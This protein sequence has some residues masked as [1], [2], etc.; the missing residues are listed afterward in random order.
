MRGYVR[1]H[2]ILI[3]LT[4]I[5][6]VLTGS[7]IFL[8]WLLNWFMGEDYYIAREKENIV[9]Q[10]YRVNQIFNVEKDD[11]FDELQKIERSSNIKIIVSS[12]NPFY[13]INI[14]YSTMGESSKGYRTLR[15][16][17]Q[18]IQ[19]YA[20]FGGVD[21]TRNI[22]KE[23][24]SKGYVIRD[25]IND[26]KQDDIILFG[27]LDCGYTVAM[28]IPLESINASAKISS[29]FL[30]RVG[31]WSTLIGSIG[32]FFVSMNFVRPI[33]EMAEAARKMSAL[34]FNVKVTRLTNDELGDLGRDINELASKLEETIS[35]LK[36][37][38]NELRKD[39][40]RKIEIDN[41]RKEFLSHVSH[42]L[43][44]PIALIQGYAEGLKENISDDE[45]SRE[46]YCEVICDE[47][48]KMNN[49]IKKL[50]TLNQIEFGNEQVKMQRF[51]ITDVARNLLASSSILFEKKNITLIFN[52]KEDIDVWADEFMIEEVFSNYISNALNHVTEGGVIT[53]RF[54]KLDLIREEKE[55]VEDNE[56]RQTPAQIEKIVRIFVRNTG[57]QIPEEDLE[58][59]WVR[60]FKVDKART[61]EYGGS[62]IGLSI[63]A[64]TMKAHGRKFGV[65]NKP[66][67]VEF[68]FDLERANK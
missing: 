57:K 42:E 67:G 11:Y 9:N 64:T 20:I 55:K 18:E 15:D 14:I 65:T 27:L 23:L 30:A 54:E 5:L 33:E 6:V 66:D 22:V 3:K 21:A 45:E 12:N 61:R 19:N 39:I 2:S 28:R 38:N 52:E 34:D 43:K 7:T 63:V 44:T 16:Y 53:V 40:D 36:T 1:R 49:M 58:K 50:L 4:T 32:I 26:K 8:A 68:Y 25:N 62:G 48:Q 60:F 29:A 17:L 51:N 35:D 59:I 24:E 56:E 10:F 37:A 31:I 41:M 47:A 13:G 46:F